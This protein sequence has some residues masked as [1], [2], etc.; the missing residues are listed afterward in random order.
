MLGI[1]LTI[2]LILAFPF[3]FPEEFLYWSQ[4]I[5]RRLRE[6]LKNRMIPQQWEKYQEEVP[7]Y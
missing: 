6:D 2:L 4:E 3:L 7:D 1:H 5:R